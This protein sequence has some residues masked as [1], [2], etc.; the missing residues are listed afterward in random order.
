MR[1]AIALG[2]NIGD[3]LANLQ[4]EFGRSMASQSQR[5]SQ[6]FMKPRRSIAN[7]ARKIFTTQLL[8]LGSRNRPMR[9]LR[10]CKTLNARWEESG[11][12]P[13]PNPPPRGEE[14]AKRQVRARFRVRLI[15][16]CCISAVNV[17][18]MHYCNC[19]IRESRNG[20]SFC[21]HC[22]ISRRIC[23]CPDKQKMW[24]SY[25]RSCR[26]RIKLRA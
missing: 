3:R 18:P 16:I 15:S 10:H 7:Q 12:R 5:C 25:S 2:S 21:N 24:A 11:S 4:I 19:R 17:A 14:D 1:A 23:V 26:I 6:R 9:F 22:V 8:K 20:N 13:H